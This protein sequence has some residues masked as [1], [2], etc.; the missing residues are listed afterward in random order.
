[1]AVYRN[2]G[3]GSHLI[4]SS[5]LTAKNLGYKAVFVVGGQH[6]ISDLVLCQSIDSPFE[7]QETFLWNIQWCSNLKRIT[8]EK[9][10]EV[11]QYVDRV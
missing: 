4:T 11:L 1:M 2:R 6:S 5:L 8:W 3:A 9:L 7:I 10:V